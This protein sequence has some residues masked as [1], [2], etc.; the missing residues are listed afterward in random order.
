MPP[1]ALAQ[2]PHDYDAEIAHVH[3]LADANRAMR[4]KSYTY[5]SYAPPNASAS[6]SVL[7]A[8]ALAEWGMCRP[9]VAGVRRGEA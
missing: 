7:L 4:L 3:A 1:A 6:T 5:P 9:P 8:T 2:Q